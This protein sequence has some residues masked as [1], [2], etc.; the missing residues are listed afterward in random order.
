MIDAIERATPDGARLVVVDAITSITGLVFPA[1]AIVERLHARG[2]PVLIDGAHVPG[3][4]PLALGTLMAD[5]FVGN[6][7]KWLF[8]CKGCAVLYVRRDRQDGVD[9]LGWSHGID[10]GFTGRFDFQGTREPSP[11]LTAE[12]ALA[13]QATH[14]DRRIRAHNVALRREAGAMWCDR[15][16][17]RPPAPESMLGALQTLPLPFPTDGTQAQADALN[18][19]LWEDHRIEAM[20]APF[21][22]RVWVRIAAQIYNHLAEYEQLADRVSALG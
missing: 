12:D 19:R 18:R 20:F 22:G 7:H 14:G 13:F 10:Q 21:R 9:P 4:L 11:W 2:I 1:Q 3:H 16:G 5:Y 15:F 8:A 17:V 6:L